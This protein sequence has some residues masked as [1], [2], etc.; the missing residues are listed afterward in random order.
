MK[1]K[2]LEEST[3]RPAF[4]EMRS[5]CQVDGKSESN[6]VPLVPGLPKID[7]DFRLSKKVPRHARFALVRQ[8]PSV[9]RFDPGQ[10]YA[11]YLDD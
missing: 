8:S 2:G 11:G 5:G 10:D 1:D 9:T 7:S 4:I 6:F 3:R